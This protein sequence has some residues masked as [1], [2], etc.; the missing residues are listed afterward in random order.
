MVLRYEVAFPSGISHYLEKLAFNATSKF[1]SKDDII[2]RLE[3]FGGICDCRS[4]RY[5]M[6][7]T[8]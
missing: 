4:A 6:I 1:E 5:I 8:E 3:E 2:H 7:E